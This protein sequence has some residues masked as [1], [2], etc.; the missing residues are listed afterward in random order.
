MGWKSV[1]LIWTN[2]YIQFL[3]TYYKNVVG[4]VEVH[5]VNQT[6]RNRES[7]R[8]SS[9]REIKASTPVIAYI[10]R[11]PQCIHKCLRAVSYWISRV[12]GGVSKLGRSERDV[13]DNP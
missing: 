3:Y 6:Y 2:P 4:R 7:T 9:P 11:I 5:I 13:E 12:Q 1:R 8:I 10:H